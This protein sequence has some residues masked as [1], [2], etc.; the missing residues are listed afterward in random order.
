MLAPMADKS[1]VERAREW[2]DQDPDPETRADLLALIDAGN[3]TELAERMHAPLE[4]GTA[5]LRGVV[6]A[7]INRMNRAV[8]IRATRGLADRL[9]KEPD[10]RTLPVVVGYD[11]RTHSRQF[12][13]DA[14]A[15]LVEAGIPVR[16]FDGP[17]STPMVAYA[18]RELSA[19]SAIVITASHNPPEYNGYKVY[20]PNAAQIVPPWD[21]E[22]A[23]AIDAVGP[24]KDVPLAQDALSRAETIPDSLFDRY[25]ADGTARHSLAV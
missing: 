9:L 11:G 19:Q 13:E 18:A 17:T 2:M 16:W 1:P 20:A 21:T 23:E 12:A 10:A 4:F 15:V 5:G 7:G 24:A 6:G 14:I 25:L 8:V 22:I 3:E